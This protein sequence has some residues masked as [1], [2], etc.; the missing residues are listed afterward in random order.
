MLKQILAA[1]VILGLAA[2]GM[3]WLWPDPDADNDESQRGGR[4]TAVNTIAPERQT[5]AETL[6]AVGTTA[7]REAV[8]ITSEVDG[9]VVELR[10]AEGDRVEEGDVLLVLDERQARADLDVAEARFEDAR[11][12]FARAERLRPTNNISEAEYDERRSQMRVAEAELEA[13]RTRLAN[14]RIEAPF[15]GTLGLRDISR[16]AYLRAGDPIT[17]LDT[18]E[19]LDLNFSVPERFIA[20]VELGQNVKAR[21]GAFPNRA[22]E[23]EV[24]ELDSRIDPRS[25]SLAVRAHL[26]NSERLLRPG[27]FLNVNLRLGEREALMVPEQAVLAQGNEHY[28]Y[29]VEDEQAKRRNLTL[30]ERRPGTVEIR[31]GLESDDRVIITGLGRIGDGDAVRVL[32]DPDVLVPTNRAVLREH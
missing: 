22:F 11:D 32:E 8:N 27:Q 29:V 30:G 31:E 10:F 1:L 4:E 25:R 7:A 12:K 18:I 21:T 20:R 3:W 14:R 9:R 23:G 17:T 15:S 24:R 6:E 13:S 16:G 28:L 19:Q 5:L 26:D 2:L